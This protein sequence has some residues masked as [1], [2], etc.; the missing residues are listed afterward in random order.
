MAASGQDY[1]GI[2]FTALKSLANLPNTT[3]DID[4]KAPL[5]ILKMTIILKILLQQIFIV[6]LVYVLRELVVEQ[7][8]KN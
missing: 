4:V 3:F 6:D 1:Y 5:P 7:I 8:H 2:N